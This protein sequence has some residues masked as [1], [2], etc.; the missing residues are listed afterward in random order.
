MILSYVHDFTICRFL[1]SEC[2]SMDYNTMHTIFTVC[3][4]ENVYYFPQYI[5]NIF[6]A[7]ICHKYVRA[8]K[9]FYNCKVSES[10][11][12][13]IHC[14]W[15]PLFL[16]YFMVF[17]N[18]L[19]SSLIPLQTINLLVGQVKHKFNQHCLMENSNM[20]DFNNQTMP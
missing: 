20:I 9:S 17:S 3:L 14:V 8:K 5:R 12:S 10:E 13:Q 4:Y 16:R 2:K 19:D 6:N 7:I 18:S 15:I 1:R 11:Y